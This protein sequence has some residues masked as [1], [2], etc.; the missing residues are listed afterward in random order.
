MS[1]PNSSYSVPNSHLSP[2]ERL[3]VIQENI[4]RRT[5]EEHDLARQ[6]AMATNSSGAARTKR[7]NDMYYADIMDQCR[8]EGEY[9]ECHVNETL[10]ADNRTRC[11]DL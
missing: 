1:S 3:K 2:L 10:R 4:N 11:T 8:G 6:I 5:R 7:Y 9:Y